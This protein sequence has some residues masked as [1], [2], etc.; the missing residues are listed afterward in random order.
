MKER[1]A[2]TSRQ[3]SS[4]TLTIRDTEELM[5]ADDVSFLQ[6]SMNNDVLENKTQFWFAD[7]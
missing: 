1:I 2:E 6:V 5:N 7:S 3:I 4:L